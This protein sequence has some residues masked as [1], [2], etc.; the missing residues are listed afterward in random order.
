METQ[1]V[2]QRPLVISPIEDDEFNTGEVYTCYSHKAVKSAMNLIDSLY[3]NARYQMHQIGP[4]ELFSLI[5]L[6]RSDCIKLMNKIIIASDNHGYINKESGKILKVEIEVKEC[7]YRK[8][9]ARVT[10]R[11][12]TKKLD[13]EE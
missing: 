5:E 11:M 10:I 7:N 2:N 9:R 3:P 12:G 4:F 13:E 6:T 1:A 8:E